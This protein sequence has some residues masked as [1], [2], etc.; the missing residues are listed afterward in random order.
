MPANR[1][2]PP[3]SISAYALST[4]DEE[5]P[6]SVPTDVIPK[7]NPFHMQVQNHPI[8]D[9]LEP[10]LLSVIERWSSPQYIALSI[11][12]YRSQGALYNQFTFL[13]V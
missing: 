5:K 10:A 2:P 3:S 6:V 12:A 4:M 8:K 1:N 9:M 11:A 7:V 13:I